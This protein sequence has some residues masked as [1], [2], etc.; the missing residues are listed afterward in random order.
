MNTKN[1]FWGFVAGFF[2]WLIMR[3]Q[4][5]FNICFYDFMKIVLCLWFFL[6]V[7]V[8]CNALYLEK[9]GVKIIWF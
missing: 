5:D 7:F 1:V 2:V 6:V 8:V 4:K 3:M 9:L